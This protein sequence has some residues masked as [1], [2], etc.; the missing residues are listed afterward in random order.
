M[1]FACFQARL[2]LRPVSAGA[3]TGLGHVH[4]S[5]EVPVVSMRKKVTETQGTL[6]FMGGRGL[7]GPI[8]ASL[9]HSSEPAGYRKG[10]PLTGSSTTALCVLI[11]WVLGIEIVT[12]SLC[13]IRV[14]SSFEFLGPLF[15][16]PNM[17]KCSVG[18]GFKLQTLGR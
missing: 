11:V 12:T 9:Y 5:A 13:I 10:S 18:H 6:A 14:S 2:P 15:S 16:S 17:E 7:L 1:L 8:F 4:S 3:F